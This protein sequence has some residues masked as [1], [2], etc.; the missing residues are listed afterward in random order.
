MYHLT[1]I[2]G[3]LTSICF[4]ISAIVTPWNEPGSIGVGSGFAGAQKQ[5]CKEGVGNGTPGNYLKDHRLHT[6]I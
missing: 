5:V 6:F 4:S 3:S 1:V 2:N